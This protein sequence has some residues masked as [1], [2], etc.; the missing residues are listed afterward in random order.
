VLMHAAGGR[1]IGVLQRPLRR[2]MHAAT[3][4]QL[5]QR[6]ASSG[7]AE[8]R[9]GA[10][11]RLYAKQVDVPLHVPALL[12]LLVPPSLLRSA[13][14]R[15]A[16]PAAAASNPA[17]AASGLS[18]VDGASASTAAAAPSTAVPL[19][20]V[21]LWLG[22]SAHSDLHIDRRPNVLTVLRGRKRVLLVSPDDA[23]RHLRPAV[24]LDVQTRAAPTVDDALKGAPRPLMPTDAQAAVVD[25][26]HFM[27]SAEETRK[28]LRA[29]A[30]ATTPGTG[31]GSAPVCS[32]AARAGDAL[33]I[34]PYWAHAVDTETA[35]GEAFAAAVNFF[36]DDA[37][38]D[39]EA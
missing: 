13:A 32:F 3:L 20:E 18:G 10:A 30:A 26:N 17:R 4:L 39:R 33:F 24:L 14:A 7:T 34:P 21:N 15:S 36:Y 37:H 23:A 19:A 27:A 38:G 6:A 35:A 2:Y 28:R 22:G 9:A 1:L 11:S 29:R 5:L 31:S 16:T 8:E 25:T 12:R